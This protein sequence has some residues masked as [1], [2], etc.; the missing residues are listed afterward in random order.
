MQSSFAHSPE[1]TPTFAGDMNPLAS[2]VNSEIRRRLKSLGFS[3]EDLA[4]RLGVSAA[5][6]SKLLGD[7]NNITLKTMAAIASALDAHWT[8]IGLTP[9]ELADDSE[10][11]HMMERRAVR[12]DASDSWSRSG[13]EGHVI[14]FC[15]AA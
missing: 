13:K 3:Q 15:A 14:D 9:D 5:R 10:F 1:S 7:H 4:T 2:V 8:G 12:S 11:E 6:V